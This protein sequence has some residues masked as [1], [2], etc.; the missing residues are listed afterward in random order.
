[1][2]ERMLLTTRRRL[3]FNF[4]RPRFLLNEDY[5]N[6]SRRAGS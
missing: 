2:D 3:L 4:I 1:M 5:H 6:G